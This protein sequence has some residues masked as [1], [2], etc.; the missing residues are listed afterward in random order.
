MHGLVFVVDGSGPGVPLYIRRCRLAL[1]GGG[2]ALIEDL[3]H[4]LGI[5]LSHMVSRSLNVELS[6]EARGND[7]WRFILNVPIA[8]EDRV[9]MERE[10]NE[11]LLITEDPYDMAESLGSEVSAQRVPGGVRAVLLREER[12]LERLE[13]VKRI[14]SFSERCLLNE[15][16]CCP[17]ILVVDEEYMTRKVLYGLLKS[18]HRHSIVME[19]VEQAL[20][21]VKRTLGRRCC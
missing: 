7:G 15:H 1:S 13:E 21:E 8:E 19:G 6:Y 12:S 5:A 9:A 11:E 16:Q 10:V 14:Y 2:G 4:G 20:E 17:D 3:R 18:L